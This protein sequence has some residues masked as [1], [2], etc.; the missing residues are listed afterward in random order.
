[1]S[2]ETITMEEIARA[3]R[4]IA[5]AGEKDCGGCRYSVTE[6]GCPFEGEWESCDVDR[7]ALDAARL[8]NRMHKAGY[9]EW[10]PVSERVPDATERVLVCRPGKNGEPVVEQGYKDVRDWWRV[11]GCRTKQVTHWMPM[12]QPPDETDILR[13][14]ERK[15]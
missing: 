12:P 6:V 8:I 11:Y 9:S 4:C 14:S 7:I 10:I 5:T 1:M 3:L 13:P 2:M 15:N